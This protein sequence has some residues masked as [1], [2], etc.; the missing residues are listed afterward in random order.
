MVHGVFLSDVSTAVGVA[1]VVEGSVGLDGVL[2][3]AGSSTPCDA[4]FVVG[5]A[6]DFVFDAPVGVGSGATLVLRTV[7]DVP[8]VVNDGVSGPA[9]PAVV[10]AGSLM[11]D[12]LKCN[13]CC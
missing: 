4:A 11:A 2:V 3:D 12:R 7:S 10:L 13:R 1:L 5:F 6:V 8:I 9:V